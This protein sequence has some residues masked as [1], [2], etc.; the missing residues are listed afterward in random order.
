MASGSQHGILAQRHRYH[1]G[2]LRINDALPLKKSI[3]P[4]IVKILCAGHQ[5]RNAKGSTGPGG[6]GLLYPRDAVVMGNPIRS[7]L[8]SGVRGL[9]LGQGEGSRN[10]SVACEPCILVCSLCKLFFLYF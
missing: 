4:D 2:S 5:D 7:I 1:L 10:L 6:G 9:V 8:G 3:M